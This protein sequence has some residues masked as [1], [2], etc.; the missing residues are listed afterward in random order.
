[1]IQVGNA[2][3]S[4][5]VEFAGDPR[6]PAWRDVLRENA[7][8]GYTGIELGP[9]GFMP[10]DPAELGE[11]LAEFKQELIGGVVFR[12]FHDPDQWDDVLDG[13]ERTIKALN[14]HGA[15]HLVLI[16]SISPRRAPTAGRWDAAEK[17]DQTEWTAYRD[18]IAHVAKMGTDAGLT[19][20][21]HAHAAGF[22]DFEPE[23]ERLLDEVPDDILKICFDTG[24]HSYAG[25]DPVA[26]LKRHMD[27]ISYM[28]F[29]DIDPI[30]KAD[31]ITK[32]TGFYDACGEGIFCKLGLGDV[33]F[34]AVRQALIDAGF[35]GWCTVEQD[36][37]PT[38]G[39]T[40][41]V[42]DARYNRQ[43]LQSIGF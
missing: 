40:S 24:H 37:D 27:R 8:A 15:K 38:L 10:E 33:D 34:P 25:F 4:W 12:P 5:G 11:A 31:V 39:N 14:A 16:D 19:V 30:V 42:D 32:S 1:M 43:Y 17:M 36:C 20:G 26:F 41:P 22:M 3:C 7:E 6:N 21:I 28:H 29:K 2:P 23:L 18:R 13:S 35:D 9:V